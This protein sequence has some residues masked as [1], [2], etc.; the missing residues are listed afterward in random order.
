[1]GKSQGVISQKQQL[2][3]NRVGRE[4]ISLRR[5]RSVKGGYSQ[6]DTFQER[7]LSEGVY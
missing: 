6:G 3:E 1:M 7:E 2:S 5:G 4:G